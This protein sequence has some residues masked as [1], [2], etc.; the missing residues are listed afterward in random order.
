MH[1]VWLLLG[2]NINPA[3]NIPRAVRCIADQVHVKAASSVWESPPAGGT[4]Q[5][6]Y[7]NAALL[8]ETELSPA[9]VQRS[10][11]RPIEDA[12]GRKRSDNKFDARTIDID[13][14]LYDSMC[15]SFDGKPLPH[16]DILTRP[17]AAIP[18]AEV[19]PE[20]LH[21]TQG[22]TLREIAL[23]IPGRNKM[24]KI[25]SNILTD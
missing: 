19:S 8:I 9:E 25:N 11:I 15:G 6:D 22:K 23:A 5:P 10:L 20:F 24:K 3:E 14:M 4:D 18:L 21:P 2:S 12:L 7:W 16:P 17:Y 1:S 13:L